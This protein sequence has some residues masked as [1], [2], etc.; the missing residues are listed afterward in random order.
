LITVFGSINL[1]LI[2][3]VDRL[4]KPGETVPGDGFSTAPGGKGANQA[5][6]AARAGADVRMIGGVGRDSFAG[7]AL[8]LL[9]EGGVDLGLVRESHAATGIALILVE[10]AGENVIAIVPGANGTV[11][12]GDVAAAGIASGEHVMLQL[13]VPLAAVEAALDAAREAGATAIL[14]TAPFRA[15]AGGLL[16]KADHVIANET[17]FD[18]YADALGLAGDGRE[19]RMLDFVERTGRRHAR[20]RRGGG[21]GALD[22]VGAGQ[23]PVDH[24]GRYGRRG[25]HVLRLFR[26]RDRERTA[27]F[28]RASS[29]RGRRFAG[30]PQARRAA[31]D[32]DGERGRRSPRRLSARAAQAARS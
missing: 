19:Q 26:R 28:R 7:E 12:A 22:R 27:A 8:A 15:E 32:P 9:G 13:E 5:L 16:A 10:K 18:L 14:N 31:F 17:E 6:A 20:R 2:A 4:P 25:R 1:D 30:M 23:G 11:A 21:C 29:R 3:T 24:A